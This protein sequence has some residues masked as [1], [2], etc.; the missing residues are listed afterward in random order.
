MKKTVCLLL[1]VL[2]MLSVL[3]CACNQTDENTSD[4]VSTDPNAYVPHLG[5]T[6]KYK[7]KTLK[8]LASAGDS[9]DSFHAF[10]KEAIDPDPSTG[11]PVNDAAYE[12]NQRIKECY[13][14]TI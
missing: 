12:R 14:I 9:A 5:A 10:C 13:G 7:G 1:S 4:E 3:L 6:D 11:E 8:I 2:M